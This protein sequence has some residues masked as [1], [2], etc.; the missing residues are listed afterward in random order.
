MAV[1]KELMDLGLYLFSSCSFMNKQQ[2]GFLPRPKLQAV[3][4]ITVAK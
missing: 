4:E 2:V 1:V 3:A